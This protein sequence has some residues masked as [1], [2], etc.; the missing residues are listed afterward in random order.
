MGTLRVLPIHAMRSFIASQDL[1]RAGPRLRDALFS[2]CFTAERFGD[3]A[4]AL[5]VVRLTT[6]FFTGGLRAGRQ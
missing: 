1:L 3:L 2:A 4:E 6:A 5:A